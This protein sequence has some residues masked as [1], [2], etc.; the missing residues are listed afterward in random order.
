MNQKKIQLLIIALLVSFILAVCGNIGLTYEPLA[1]DY[2]NPKHW[3]SLPATVDKE[4]DVFYL[5]P[6]AWQKVN[7]NDPN[8]CEIDNPSMLIGAKA[9]FGRQ[10][11]VFETI[12]NI[13]T[14]YYR[15]ADLS[16]VDREKVIGGLPTLDAVAAF[17]YYIK[18]YNQ[19][20]SFILAGHSQGSNVLSNL[21]AGYMKDHPEVL[22]NM[23]AAYVIGFPVTATYLAQNPHL[24]FAEGPDDIGVI[25]SYNTEAPDVLPGTNPVLSGMVGLVINPI[26]WTREETLATT[27][28]GKGSFLPD[29]VSK[30]FSRVP[31]YADA[32]IDKTKGVVICSTADENALYSLSGALGKGVYH[33]FDYLFYYYNIRANAENRVSK[34]LEGRGIST[35]TTNKQ[36]LDGVNSYAPLSADNVNLI[37]VVSPGLAYQSPG[38]IN[39]N[40]ANLTN[41]GLQRSLLMATYLKQ[42]VLGINN[43]TSI[44]AL[45]PMT[46]LQTVNNYP[47]MTAIGYIQQFALLNQFTQPLPSPGVTYTANSY[48]INAAYGPGSVPDGVVE[49]AIGYCPDCQGLDFNN[50]GGN[51]DAL[52]SGIINKKIPGY[53]VFS[54][55]WEIIHDLLVQINNFYGYNLDLPTTYRGSN[56]VYAISITRSGSASLVTYNS[57]LNPPS[58][59]PVLPS[60]VDSTP[61]THTQQAYFRTVRTGG[62]DGVI[63]PANINT[64]QTIHIIRHAEAHPGNI[65]DENNSIFENGNLVGAGQW[66]ALE[67]PN[68]LRGKISPDLVYSIDPAQWAPTRYFNL[69][70]VRP[71]LTVLPYA[72]AND[73]P[74]YLVS[75]FFIGDKNVAQLASDFFFTGGKFSNQTVLLAWE[76]TR[77]K[78]L[79]NALL[80]SYGGSNLP[81]LEPA[82]PIAD[83]DTIWTVTLDAQGNL[84]VD[85]DLCEGIDTTK[86][87][88]TAPQF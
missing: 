47:D 76:S 66:R 43:V 19:G 50:T 15:Q 39:P 30:A 29:P 77:I 71:S 44:Y 23:I 24:K 8:I 56:Y 78:P 63:I 13:Y 4:V 37:L 72:I 64:K 54:A 38:D 12:G 53:Y 6:T 17:D 73:L 48:P 61:C 21:L 52:V 2:S 26:T 3:L 45:A 42:R 65:L 7:E 35:I 18:Y 1:N 67:L 22:K 58:T 27:S 9:A 84:T 10:A 5:Y 32:K 14:P 81:L 40:T 74:Y 11:T 59:Y 28:E 79:I 86:L 51:N 62:V 20:R 33:S 16:P 75:S 55:P 82:W 87:P 83:Y 41:Q 85:N 70:Y 69:S 34:Y 60:P 31:Q 80:E 46:H 68:A 57:N 25:I 36:P 88:V 49:P